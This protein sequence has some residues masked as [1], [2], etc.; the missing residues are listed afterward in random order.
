MDESKII[1]G[2]KAREEKAFSEAIEGY[3]RLL[4]V[5]AGRHLSKADGFS[6]RDIEE[7]IADVFFDLWRQNERYDSNKGSLKSYL[8]VLTSR[9]AI[10][11]YRKASQ[12]KILSFEDLRPDDEPYYIEMVDGADHHSLYTAIAELPEPTRE[13]LIRRYF[14]EQQPG[15]IAAKM[16]LPKKE[17]E[18]RLYRAKQSL[19]RTLPQSLKEALS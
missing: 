15:A 2:L 12:T 4:W 19:S 7:C 10:S 5:V 11:R 14:Y 16:H 8:C 18:N 3:S 9:K 6:D 17:V 13:V 1:K